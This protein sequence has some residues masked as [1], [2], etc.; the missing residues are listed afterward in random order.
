M[1]CEG[2]DLCFCCRVKFR[3]VRLG[4]K[5]DRVSVVYIILTATLSLF[6]IQFSC[7]LSF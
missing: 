3:I 4:I 1:I 5:D 2:Y 7:K 6:I